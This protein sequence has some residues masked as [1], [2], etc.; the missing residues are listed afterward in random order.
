MS[1]KKIFA[2]IKELDEMQ[3]PLWSF[4]ERVAKECT[5]LKLVKLAKSLLTKK[6]NSPIN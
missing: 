4:V 3:Q 1:N 6:P 2:A 5:D